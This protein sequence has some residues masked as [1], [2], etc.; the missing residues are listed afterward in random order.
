MLKQTL[1]AGAAMAGAML[2]SAPAFAVTTYASGSTTAQSPSGLTPIIDFTAPGGTAVDVSVLDCCIVGDYYAAY[3]DGA[4]IGTSP[5]EP[6]YGSTPSAATFLA[7]LGAGSS[8]T[9][10]F[11]DQTDFLLPAG[12][13]YSVTSASVPEP[14]TWGLMLL[15]VGGL[16]GVLRGRR[17]TG[18]IGQTA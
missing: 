16:G 5:F 9:L 17:K 13:S 8:H 12:L 15:G 1:V 11:A 4:Y 3:L 14:A 2:L 10:Q 18:L 7:T 6:E